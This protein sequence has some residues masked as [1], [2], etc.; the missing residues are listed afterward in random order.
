MKLNIKAYVMGEWKPSNVSLIHL[1]LN[2]HI[3]GLFHNRLSLLALLFVLA[4]LF[5]PQTGRASQKFQSISLPSVKQSC[6]F[7][8]PLLKWHNSRS[9]HT[10]ELESTSSISG[11][12]H[13]KE[14]VSLATR[15]WGKAWKHVLPTS[16]PG[17]PWCCCLSGTET[18]LETRLLALLHMFTH[19]P[20]LPITCSLIPLMQIVHLWMGIVSLLPLAGIV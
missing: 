8:F 3:P 9:S 20:P 2:F 1:S 5:S 17:A 18:K 16:F 13:T 14:K 7:N 12:C 19:W 10:L 4:L 15:T 6:L 11:M